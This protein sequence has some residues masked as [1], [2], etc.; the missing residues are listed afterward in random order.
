[1]RKTNVFLLFL[2]L[3][4]VDLCAFTLV[5]KDGQRVEGTWVTEDRDTIF[6]KDEKGVVR[7]YKKSGL[8]MKATAMSRMPLKDL[9]KS[10][11]VEPSRLSKT[12][13]APEIT[14]DV[15][16]GVTEVNKPEAKTAAVSPQSSITPGIRTTEPYE[17]GIQLPKNAPRRW[18]MDAGFSN[19][20]ESNIHHDEEDIVESVGVV[21][22]LNMRF[23]NRTTDPNYLLR[24]EV[25]LHEYSNT[26]DWDRVSHNFRAA[27][28][29]YLGDKFVLENAGE[30][31]LNGS[32]EDR[33]RS[34]TF[35]V[36]PTLGYYINKST[37]LEAFA[38]YRHRKLDNGTKA[39]N[40]YAGFGFLKQLKKHEI[41][42]Y[43][44]YEYNDSENF[45]NDR[46]V[47]TYFLGFA[48][49]VPG[50]LT[51]SFGTR[52]RDYRYLSRLVEIEVEDGDDI[53]FLREDRKWNFKFALEIPIGKRFE[54]V[55]EY[56]YEVRSS[57]DPEKPYDAHGVFL[58]VVY[59]LW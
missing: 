1:M 11:K 2:L 12:A 13:Q 53:E 16:P 32:S 36:R 19:V 6:V 24:Y 45:R 49:P 7:A 44:R 17:P 41:E 20:Y 9:K 28:M 21:S 23:R 46:K 34:D 38:A 18:S 27:H 39:L 3:N 37:R 43:Y 52:L 56:E 14:V 15:P 55:P 51:A 40:R 5:F 29:L 30:I 48:M 22:S 42:G 8:D 50:D 59:S 33:E 4:A 47:S 35:G 54:L 58:S 25:G 31:A 10:S 26:D 57:N